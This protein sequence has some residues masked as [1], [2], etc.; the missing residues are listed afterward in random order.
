MPVMN[1][2]AA[3]KFDGSGGQKSVNH[4]KEIRRWRGKPLRYAPV[5]LY[6]FEVAP[7]FSELALHER[8]LKAVEEL[9]FAE[10]TPVQA[11]A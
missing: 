9:K 2:P 6:F 5:F 10:P 4:A 1:R 8:L 11:A 3:Y 7:V